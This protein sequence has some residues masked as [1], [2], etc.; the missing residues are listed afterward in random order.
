[1][2]IA[3]TNNNRIRLVYSLY[4][5]AYAQSILDCV[6]DHHHGLIINNDYILSSS[7]RCVDCPSLRV[8]YLRLPYQEECSAANF[9]DPSVDKCSLYNC[10]TDYSGDFYI[11]LSNGMLYGIV[12]SNMQLVGVIL[13]LT[14]FAFVSL[15]S[16]R[17]L[18]LS[19]GIAAYT[20]LPLVDFM[21]D[22]VY[23]L[24]QP[25]RTSVP[26]AICFILLLFP[27][28]H[29][30]YHLVQVKA[31]PKMWLIEMPGLL[32]FDN[33]DNIFKVAY[34][35]LGYLV[36]SILNGNIILFV[37]GGFLYATKL[38]PI[39]TASNNWYFCWI[40]DNRLE[41][42]A[43]ALDGALFNSLQSSE[44]LLESLPQFTLQL[45][46]AVYLSRLGVTDFSLISILSITVSSIS[47]LHVLYRIVYTKL[48][49]G[50]NLSM[51]PVDLTL[52]GLIPSNCYFKTFLMSDN[53]TSSVSVVVDDD[54]Q[55]SK[56]IE[57]K[58]RARN[59]GGEHHM[60][61]N[62][63]SGMFELHEKRLAQVEETIRLLTRNNDKER[64]APH[65]TLNPLRL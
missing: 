42:K 16:V 2:Y 8:S 51:L 47:M 19:A 4:A 44:L 32:F 40:G 10:F 7:G 63:I 41:N 57:F 34:T 9:I 55:N 46:N 23:F 25:F 33:Y 31:H 37:L 36:F 18:W 65:A 48:Y 1:M 58:K 20:I 13:P 38:F 26:L 28:V 45:I 59:A 14:L 30:A 60:D 56:F 15:L 6:A 43:L 17:N 3:D 12:A 64:S 27:W 53:C 54:V 24:S 50:K 39:A 11:D 21:T 35:G 29:F 49:H 62:T 61:V 5:D 22:L 52:G